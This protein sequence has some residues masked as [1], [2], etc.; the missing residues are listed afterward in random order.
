[1][2]GTWHE[3]LSIQEWTSYMGAKGYLAACIETVSIRL[4]YQITAASNHTK[5]MLA[6]RHKRTKRVSVVASGI[7]TELISSVAPVADQCD[8]LYVGRLVKDKN[9][10]KMILAF[11]IIAKKNK[12]AQCVIIGHGIEKDNLVNLITERKLTKCVRILDPLPSDVDVYAYMKK[13]SVFVLPSTREGFGIVALEALACGTPV[14]T[15][16]VATNAAR[17]LIADG[18]TGSIVSISPAE[19]AKAIETWLKN[20]E[21]YTC[22]ESHLEYDWQ[23][24]AVN[25]VGVYV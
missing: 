5:N 11:E 23:K 8:V 15:S 1:M 13:A 20:A 14:V 25:Q 10:D 24:I 4:P 18:E 16:N 3:A 6:S 2:Y 7:D 22:N 17:H 21:N 12:N 19:I 9:I